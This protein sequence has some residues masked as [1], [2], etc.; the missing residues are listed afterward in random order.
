MSS[1]SG[2]PPRSTSTLARSPTN[3]WDMRYPKAMRSPDLRRVEG[4][5]W[6][7]HRETLEP[8]TIA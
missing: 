5:Q 6:A 7:Y 2:A 8:Q 4:S 1:C 3:F